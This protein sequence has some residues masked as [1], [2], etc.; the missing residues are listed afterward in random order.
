LK[1]II[2]LALVFGVGLHLWLY[3]EV[4]VDTFYRAPPPLRRAS[5]PRPIR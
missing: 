3:D 5:L 4:I 2:M 1:R